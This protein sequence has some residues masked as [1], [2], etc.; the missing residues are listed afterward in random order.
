MYDELI[1][2]HQELGQEIDFSELKDQMDA[3]FLFDILRLPYENIRKEILAGR[4]EAR[5]KINEEFGSPI[6][7][8]EGFGLRHRQLGKVSEKIPDMF[9]ISQKE[10]LA[11]CIVDWEN[12]A[13]AA[14]K[15]DFDVDLTFNDHDL[16]LLEEIS[17]TYKD[18]PIKVT[19]RLI[20]VS[21]RN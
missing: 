6:K 11:D 15:E 8:S 20:E 10:N 3:V 19:R 16:D 1:G 17:T 21:E 5:C 13:K 4:A 14:L 7:D 12:S 18:R 9:E 2:K